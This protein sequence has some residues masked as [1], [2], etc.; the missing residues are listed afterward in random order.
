MKLF[1]AV[2]LGIAIGAGVAVVVAARQQDSI[3]SDGAAAGV[4]ATM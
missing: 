1:A 2:V 4:A 3:V